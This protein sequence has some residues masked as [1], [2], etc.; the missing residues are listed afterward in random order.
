MADLAAPPQPA[1]RLRHA[2]T[3]L[4]YDQLHERA[5]VVCRSS[6]P[7][8]MAAGHRTVDGLVWAVVAC[9]EHIEEAS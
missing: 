7:P 2:D 6:A 1:A 5:C 8:L 4:T 9:A 3:L